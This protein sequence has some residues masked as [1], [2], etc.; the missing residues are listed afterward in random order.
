MNDFSVNDF[1]IVPGGSLPVTGT[2]HGRGVEVPNS[3]GSAT[4]ATMATYSC[5]EMAE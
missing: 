4:Q 5:E 3:D 1:I 2:F